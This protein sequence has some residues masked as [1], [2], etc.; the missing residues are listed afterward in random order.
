MR[1]T[2]GLD[3]RPD[4]LLDLLGRDQPARE[5]DRAVLQT[6]LERVRVRKLRE[7]ALDRHAVALTLPA[8]GALPVDREHGALELGRGHAGRE[9]RA[10]E[11]THAR[12]DDAVHRDVQ[13]V[14]HAKDADVRGAFGAAA[15]EH[16][17]DSRAR[18]RRRRWLLRARRPDHR[19]TDE[20]RKGRSPSL[21][22]Q[23]TPSRATRTTVPGKNAGGQLRIVLM[24]PR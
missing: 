4:R 17:S 5:P 19:G 14:E 8:D 3:E 24:N 7:L 21:Q 11:R 6:D 23:R 1:V 2:R 13:L 22:N 20:T 12:A 10:D 16:E 18:R 15:R 9:R